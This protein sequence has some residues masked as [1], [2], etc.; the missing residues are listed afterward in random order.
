MIIC[1]YR[2]IMLVGLSTF[3]TMG[4]RITSSYCFKILFPIFFFFF[5]GGVFHIWTFNSILLVRVTNP[6][7]HDWKGG[8]EFHI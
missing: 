1:F 2:L 6:E 8:R 4:I 3:F 7:F 5:V